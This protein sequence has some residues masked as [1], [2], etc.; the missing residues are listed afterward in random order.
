M[1]EEQQE[2]VAG[3]VEKVQNSVTHNFPLMQFRTNM[4]LVKLVSSNSL[5]SVFWRLVQSADYVSQ[6]L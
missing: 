4:K 1:D 2:Q 6:I 3:E 5:M